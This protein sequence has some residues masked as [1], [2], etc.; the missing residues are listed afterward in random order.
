VGRGSKVI[1]AASKGDEMARGVKE[2]ACEMEASF[3][4]LGALFIAERIMCMGGEG[5]LEMNKKKKDKTSAKWPFSFATA[6]KT[7]KR[8]QGRG[9]RLI[10]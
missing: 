9:W 5:E 2:L 10:D 1:G 3:F 8:C 4:G 7:H 6:S